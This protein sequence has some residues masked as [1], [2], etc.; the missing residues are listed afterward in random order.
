MHRNEYTKKSTYKNKYAKIFEYLL[1]H[2][3]RAKNFDTKT[4]VAKIKPQNFLRIYF[5]NNNFCVKNFFAKSF[6]I[7]IF[8][9]FVFAMVYSAAYIF[10]CLIKM[11]I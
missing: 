5:C 7:T 11:T 4:D 3:L 9:L 6:C 10:V 2:N 8:C 1:H